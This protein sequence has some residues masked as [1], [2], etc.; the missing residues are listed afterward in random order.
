[1]AEDGKVHH[2]L[3]SRCKREFLV[4]FSAKIPRFISE[5]PVGSYLDAVSDGDVIVRLHEF[6]R[7]PEDKRLQVVFAIRELAV[8]TPDAGFLH[9]E[10]RELHTSSELAET[11]TDV[12]RK[13]L[14]NIRSTIEKWRDNYYQNR[15]EPESHFEPIVSALK[16]FQ[17]ELAAY[18]DSAKQ[19]ESAL[20]DIKETVMDIMS[21][22]PEP[23]FDDDYRGGSSRSDDESRSIFDDVDH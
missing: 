3:S 14:P 17:E 23:E 7:L 15:E 11:L 5:L 2:F 10:I 6:G 9:K 12:K 1:L 16:E 8:D 19:I 20:T 22:A 18:S 21:D 13:L 4:A